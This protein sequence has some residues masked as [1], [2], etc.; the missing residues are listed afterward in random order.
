[1]IKEKK[2]TLRSNHR[3]FPKGSEIVLDWRNERKKK[4]RYWQRNL[5]KGRSHRKS[6]GQSKLTEREGDAF[7]IILQGKGLR[8]GYEEKKIRREEKGRVASS[9]KGQKKE[10][11]QN[12]LVGTGTFAKKISKKKLHTLKNRKGS[13]RKLSEGDR[14]Q[15]LEE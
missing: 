6:R 5:R 3:G 4:K 12:F 14:S 15:I 11:S 10:G 2:K 13:R 8:L 9:S 7:D 1:M